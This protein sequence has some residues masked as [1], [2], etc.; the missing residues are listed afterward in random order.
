M[1]VDTVPIEETWDLTRLFADD[2][3]FEVARAELDRHVPDLERFKGR[4]S[5]T[6]ASLSEA[7]DEITETYKKFALLRCYGIDTVDTHRAASR[8]EA[9]DAARALGYPVANPSSPL[10]ECR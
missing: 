9:L 8:D 1:P 6:A 10:A 4:L 5:S 3:A 7:L 2:D